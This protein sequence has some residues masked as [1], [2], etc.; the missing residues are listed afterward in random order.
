[1]KQNF[2]CYLTL[3]L[4]KLSINHELIVYFFLVILIDWYLMPTL[5]VFQLHHG[6]SD[7]LLL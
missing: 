2:K 1:M 7:Y 5:V 4:W 6:F 3:L